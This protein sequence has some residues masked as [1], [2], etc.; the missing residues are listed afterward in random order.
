[1]PHKQAQ[2]SVDRYS[3]IIPAGTR[4]PVAVA[5]T[6]Y[7]QSVEGVVAEKFLGNLA[8]TNGDS[9]LEPCVL[10]GL[11]D[12]RI[13]NVEPAVVEG[14]PPVPMVT[15]NLVISISGSAVENF[16]PRV[17]T[18][19]HA[20]AK[21]VYQDV[22]VKT[23]FSQPVVGVDATTFFLTDSTGGRVAA[24]VSQIG[25]ATWGLFPDQVFL[26]GGQSYTAHLQG[27]VCSSIGQC[28]PV[29]LA[30]T[31]TVT[32]VRGE[33]KGNTTVPIGFLR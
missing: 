10:G 17:A 14:A 20:G 27:R 31:F 5:A 8:D 19:P 16:V 33:G 3:V 22:V 26:K 18:Y 25:D 7:Y 4:G 13:P 12:G 23:T 6:V 28:R 15:R 32:A 24:S 2:V 9:V 29:R 1:M 11:C 21:G 30:W